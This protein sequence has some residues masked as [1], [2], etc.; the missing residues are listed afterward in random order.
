M[1]LGTQQPRSSDFDKTTFNIAIIVVFAQR[2]KT[3]IC[4]LEIGRYDLK[5]MLNM[6]KMNGH[7]LFSSREIPALR[8]ALVKLLKHCRLLKLD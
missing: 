4:N 2:L 5:I 8:D 3:R 7:M 1:T 6:N